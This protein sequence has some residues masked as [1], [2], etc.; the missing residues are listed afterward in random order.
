MSQQGLGSQ[1]SSDVQSE[2]ATRLIELV[3]DL[4]DCRD[5]RQIMVATARHFRQLFGDFMVAAYVLSD[6]SSGHWR[7]LALEN[8]YVISW[9]GIAHHQVP[10]NTDMDEIT[11][12][13]GRDVTHRLLNDHL[14][15]ERLAERRDAFCATD[16]VIATR[17]AALIGA[18]IRTLMAVSWKRPVGGGHCW[19]VLGYGEPQEISPELLQL[20]GTVVGVTS[21][22]GLYPAL[23][24][25]IDRTERINHS[26]RQNIVH[27]L[28]TP[29]TV[30]RGYA[31]TL[32]DPGVGK[33]KAMR[34]EFL[35]A[36]IDSCE[37]LLED[38]KDLL[39]TVGKAWEPNMT[40]FDLS[41][42]LQKACMAEKHTDRAHHHHI[43]LAGVDAPVIM[44][45]DMR[46]I[47]RVVENLLSNAV[48]YSPGRDKVVHVELYV[49]DGE[50]HISFADDG[51]GMTEDQLEKVL[52][53]G[54][55]VVDRSLGI[56]GSGFGLQSSKAVLTAHGG[57]LEAQSMPN[58]GTTFTAVL[59]LAMS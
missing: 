7:V 28:K 46:K 25:F 19:L 42:V 38:L 6:P 35:G 24:D 14:L 57:R 22:M 8:P 15:R 13:L 48:K 41:R 51:V 33:D 43:E 34:E 39:E 21:R 11:I 40:E 5:S 16:N 20:Y 36:I 49:E 47:R 50:A 52:S 37:R 29:L 44:L 12:R 27:D 4:G 17:L 2:I 18:P 23:V 53:D 26:V 31:E 55:R 54:G 10:E 56:E 30:I 1:S 59:P 32:N 9:G 45:G 3:R 58:H